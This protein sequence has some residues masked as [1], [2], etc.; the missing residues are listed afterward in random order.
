MQRAQAGPVFRVEEAKYELSDRWK[1]LPGR[2]WLL[3]TWQQQ[4]CGV[5]AWTCWHMAWEIWGEHPQPLRCSVTSAPPAAMGA[6]SKL[7]SCGCARHP[8]VAQG[9]P[10]GTH[11]ALESFGEAEAAALWAAPWKTLRAGSVAESCCGAGSQ[12]CIQVHPLPAGSV[13]QGLLER[14]PR[15]AGADLIRWVRVRAA[16][17]FQC[18]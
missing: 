10:G 15:K 5:T 16:C 6:A 13:G 18:L 4:K 14:Q 3:P 17:F 1:F 12:V 7:E 11:L 8:S 9:S 2:S